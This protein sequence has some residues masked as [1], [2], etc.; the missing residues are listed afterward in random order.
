MILKQGD[1]SEIVPVQI[2]ES[3]GEIAAVIEKFHFDYD[4]KASIEIFG[5]NS[6]N[7]SLTVFDSHDDVLF[8]DTVLLDKTGH[9]EYLLDLSGYKRGNYYL[10]LNHASEETIEEF[11]VGLSIGTTPIEI[12]VDDNYYK[13][14]ETVILIG[15]SSDNTQILI[16]LVDPIGEVIDEIDYYTDDDG[17]FTYQLELSLGKQSGFWTVKVS[18]GER[19]SEVIFEV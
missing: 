18:N 1:D 15:E 13:I 9:A 7:I 5:P 6:E 17:K 12:Q 11:T 14:G 16:E 19:I 3:A 2:G 10:V 8:E 4:S